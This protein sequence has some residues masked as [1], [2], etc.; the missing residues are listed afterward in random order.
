MSVVKTTTVLAND[1]VIEPGQE[2]VSDAWD[3]EDFHGGSL[4]VKATNGPTGLTSALS[5]QVQ[6]SSDG[7]NWCTFG[8]GLGYFLTSLTAEEVTS[9]QLDIPEAI[10][11]LRILASGNVGDDVT[12]FCAGTSVDDVIVQAPTSGIG[13]V[14]WQYTVTDSVTGLPIDGVQCI[15]TSD[16]LGQN[17]LASALTNVNGIATFYLNTGTIYV[18]RVKAGYS[19]DNP[20]TEVVA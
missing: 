19:F 12:L 15:V 8:R 3:V 18:W 2:F 1:E 11:Y 16:I 14:T 9:F 4:F 10:N 7:D 17:T 5:I 13:S 6:V 20:D